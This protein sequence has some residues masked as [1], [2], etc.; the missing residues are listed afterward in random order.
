MGKEKDL[1]M[2]NISGVGVLVSL[3]NEILIRVI[4]IKRK[5]GEKTGEPSAEMERQV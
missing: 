2:R 1:K 3:P 5:V 4:I